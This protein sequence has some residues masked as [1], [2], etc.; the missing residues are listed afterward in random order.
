MI[1]LSSRTSDRPSR[2][3][4]RRG[5]SLVFVGLASS[6]FAAPPHPLEPATVRDALAVNIHF[7]APRPGEMDLLKATGVGRVRMD[8]SWH[9]VEKERGVYDFSALDGLMRELDAQGLRAMLILNYGNALYSESQHAPPIA[10]E[11][12]AAFVKYAAAT[13]ARFKGRGVLWEIYNEPNN[14]QF[15]SPTPDGKAYAD[16][17]ADAA[18]AIRAVAPDEVL[19]GPGMALID[20]PF[21]E[22]ATDAGLLD[23]IDAVTVHPY[24]QTAPETFGDELAWLRKSVADRGKRTP[25]IAGEW[26]YPVVWVDA[27]TQVNYLA[28]QMLW[29]LSEGLPLNV[30]YDWRRG[31]GY[32]GKFSIFGLVDPVPAADGS[33][34]LRTTALYDALSGLTRLLGDA[35]FAERLPLD[36]GDARDAYLLAF[37]GP[38]GR[39]YAFWTSGAERQAHVR[40]PS[41]SYEF[42]DVFGRDVGARV[43]RE[44]GS[45]QQVSGS[46]RYAVRT[47]D[48][49]ATS[50]AN[51][52]TTSPVP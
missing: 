21:F 19:C 39:R 41:G 18:R 12:R 10:P 43:V 46:P 26:G 22:K 32:D 23:M 34:T 40:L 45:D 9:R 38:T 14:K 44:G 8:A 24:R 37:D 13:V 4:W 48:A 6:A 11:A 33:D 36:V 29:G 49:P 25:I 31:G 51:L 2:V 28:R 50:P 1:S 35:R 27:T 16:L 30:W 3:T 5:L 15:W 52:I 42:Y 17:A 7:L 47:G 20:K